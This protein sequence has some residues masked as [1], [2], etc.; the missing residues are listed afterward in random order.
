[1]HVRSSTVITIIE[2]NHLPLPQ[3]LLQLFFPPVRYCVLISLLRSDR[4]PPRRRRITLEQRTNERFI[5]KRTSPPPL[6]FL[7]LL[8]SLFL[9]LGKPYTCE[10]PIHEFPSIMHADSPSLSPF[11]SLSSSSRSTRWTKVTKKKRKRKKKETIGLVEKK[12]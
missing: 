3:R 4:H 11:L 5:Q 1:M 6:L 10:I 9:S 8:L 2:R 7:L 12:G